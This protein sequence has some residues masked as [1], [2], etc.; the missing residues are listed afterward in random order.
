M[1]VCSE[2]AGG[3]P[4]VDMV[5]NLSLR[6]EV[7]REVV[8]A[9]R[10]WHREVRIPLKSVLTSFKE[11]FRKRRNTFLSILFGRLSPRTHFALSYR[12]SQPFLQ[13]KEKEEEHDPLL[14]LIDQV[15]LDG[16]NAEEKPILLDN[17]A[18][19]PA[20]NIANRLL[21]ALGRTQVELAAASV[22]LY[23][24]KEN[25]QVYH[26]LKRADDMLR[27][28]TGCRKSRKEFGRIA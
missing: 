13:V 1:S 16:T 28:R 5:V 27:T 9:S 18:I 11:T 26:I 24:V 2:V 15:L 12:S 3:N 23:R 14:K 20:M 7:W 25:A 8:D 6:R 21:S 10:I 19:E 17:T 4:A 22:A